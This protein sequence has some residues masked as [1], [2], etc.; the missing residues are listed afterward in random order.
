LEALAGGAWLGF[1]VDMRRVEFLDAR[2]AATGQSSANLNT[3]R[4]RPR[5]RF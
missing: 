4:D 3:G 1:K 2:R 5:K